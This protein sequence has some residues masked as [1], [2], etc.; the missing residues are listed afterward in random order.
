M[1]LFAASLTTSLVPGSVA[2]NSFF[3]GIFALIHIQIAAFL[4]GASTLA[5][6]SEV[7]AAWR[8]DA[9]HARLAR[10][11]IKAITY[12]F[13]FGS[14]LAIFWVIIIFATLW[15]KFFI[16]LN[17]IV[18]WLFLF[19]ALF[20]L[21]EIVA[22]YALYGNYDKLKD[23]PKV[24]IGMLIL[25]NVSFFWQVFL[26]DVVASYM[27]TPNGGDIN[28]LAQVL[29]PTFLPLELHRI[30]GN[31]A[32]AGAALAFI[33]GIMVLVSKRRERLSPVMHSVGAM[34]VTEHSSAMTAARKNPYLPDND[35][36]RAY[37]SA[38]WDWAGMWGLLF[39]FGFTLLQPWIG[40]SYAKEIQLSAFESWQQMMIGSL[41]GMFLVQICLLGLAF[42]FGALYFRMRLGRIGAKTKMSTVFL[43][44][45]ILSWLLAIQPVGNNDLP[46]IG[47]WV[48]PLG[49]M[50]PWKI[51]ALFGMVLFGVSALT[52]YLKQAGLSDVTW[53]DVSKKAQWTLII[54]G[55]IVSS[56]MMVMGF[57]RENARTPYIV[58]GEIH[59][60]GQ[61]NIQ[62]PITQH[63]SN[64]SPNNPDPSVGT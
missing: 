10:G 19:E 26:I 3:V 35:E 51:Y 11:L 32:W 31:I 16:E 46:L 14:A 27:L 41:S 44:L 30:I 52:V 38:F 4:V 63:Q 36:Q 56:I 61:Q 42:V 45:L 60:S 50:F 33:S 47:F 24:K 64:P 57:I 5:I 21:C 9:R 25:L 39:G 23:Y 49:A 55:L 62:N 13:G 2:L 18:F 22:L 12:F 29:N 53:G 48:S 28:Q 17:Q 20:F 37:G 15:G 59:I 58:E 40:Y 1:S 34:S 54:F 7:I 43:V 6:V 8:G